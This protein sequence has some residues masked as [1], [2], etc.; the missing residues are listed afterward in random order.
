MDRVCRAVL[1][2]VTTMALAPQCVAGLS[3]AVP[4]ALA[5]EAGTSWVRGPA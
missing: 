5:R 4:D 2:G 3:A 1:N